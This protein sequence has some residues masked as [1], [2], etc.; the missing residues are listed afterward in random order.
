VTKDQVLALVQAHYA[1][2]RERF[3]LSVRQIASTFGESTRW[4]FERAIREMAPAAL[5]LLPAESK[6]L[7]EPLTSVNRADLVLSESL[8]VGLDDIVREHSGR[9]AFVGRGIRHRSR[10]LFTGPPGCGKT[11]TAGALA[12]EL[13]MSAFRVSVPSLVESFMGNTAKHVRDALRALKSNVLLVL[14]ELDAIGTARTSGT[15]GADREWNVVVSTL[16]TELDAN[17]GDGIFIATTNRPELLDAALRRRFDDEFEF[18]APNTDAKEAL[19]RA[20]WA[21]WE[22][23]PMLCPKPNGEANFDAVAKMVAK[24]ARKLVL[25][26][27]EQSKGAA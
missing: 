9:A 24:A 22:L 25:D 5:V 15:S 6:E 27:A 4:Q 21:K 13:S 14:D 17:I 8:S 10:L 19:A 7:L 16:L 3:D 2:N 12:A 23:E 18:A 11:S 20:L 1:G 26:E